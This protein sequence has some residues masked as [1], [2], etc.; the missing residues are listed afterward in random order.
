MGKGKTFSTDFSDATGG[1][2][3]EEEATM[4]NPV[5]WWGF[6]TGM[7]SHRWRPNGYVGM[8]GN[9]GKSLTTNNKKTPILS[10]G[11]KKAGWTLTDDGAAIN[12]KGQRFIFDN[13]RWV[14]EETS[15]NLKRV[16][17]K[18]QETKEKSKFAKQIKSII[19]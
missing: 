3:S 17:L 13:G 10:E 11:M 1:R 8:N 9:P 2:L 6:K 15:K 7:N 16:K 18:E 4:L 19:H 5:T 12:S 14:T